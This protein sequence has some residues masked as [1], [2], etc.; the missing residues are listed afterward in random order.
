MLKNLLRRIILS[1]SLISI[2][3]AGPFQVEALVKGYAPLPEESLSP[4]DNGEN[5]LK[6]V[7]VP[8]EDSNSPNKL[9]PKN[10]LENDS[11][12]D[13]GSDQIFPFEPG[14]G[15]HSGSVTGIN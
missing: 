10:S 8:L 12:I 14:L 6:I 13:L 15:N 3:L 5:P 1:I 7:I 2:L 4:E 11:A 9:E